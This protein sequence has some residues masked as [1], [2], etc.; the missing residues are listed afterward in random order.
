[1]NISGHK[2]RPHP[3]PLPQERGQLRRWLVNLEAASVASAIRR[4]DAIGSRNQ[5]P[6]FQGAG[7][8]VP[9]SPGGSHAIGLRSTNY[10][11][12]AAIDERRTFESPQLGGNDSPSP[13]GR[14]PG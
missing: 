12:A 10:T 2:A 1:M 8:S 3:Y 14:G 11:L 6:A 5:E 4:I 7:V 9:P 13:R